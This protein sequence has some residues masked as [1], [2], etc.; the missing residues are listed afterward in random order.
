MGNKEL[1]NVF[2]FGGKDVRTI[3]IE[4]IPYFVGKDVAEV[5]GYSNPRKAII[6]HVDCEDKIDGVTI[7]DSIG[8]E[9]EPVL[10]NES[11]LYSLIL[12]SKLPQAKDFKRWV[13]SV[14][15]P[16]I[17]HTGGF[18]VGTSLPMLADLSE[19]EL[20]QIVTSWK[21]QKKFP[22]LTPQQVDGCLRLIP[23]YPRIKYTE[24]ARAVC[25]SCAMITLIKDYMQKLGV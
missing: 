11:G 16:A 21:M 24:I 15:L 20:V 25:L 2:S 8:R 18:S 23:L 19:N 6:D 12:S 22:S 5:L 3:E 9:Q 14:V 7:R 10:I 1:L 13:T 4:R 17:R